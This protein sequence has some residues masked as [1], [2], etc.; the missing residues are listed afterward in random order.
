M[1]SI[2]EQS[3]LSASV[4]C[5]VHNTAEVQTLRRSSTESGLHPSYWRSLSVALACTKT[6]VGK[7]AVL[8]TYGGCVE[9]LGGG[10]S[11]QACQA[12]G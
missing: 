10:A 3:S 12:C 11:K 6:R 1:G 4:Y 8:L 7:C 9:P 2:V 5:V